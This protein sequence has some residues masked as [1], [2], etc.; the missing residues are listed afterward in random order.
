[1]I[2]KESSRNQIL[3]ILD[4]ITLLILVL[5]RADAKRIKYLCEKESGMENEKG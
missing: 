2:K 3:G 5:Q 4:L 1:M